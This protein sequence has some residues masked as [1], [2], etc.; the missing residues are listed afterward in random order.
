MERGSSKSGLLQEC[1]TLPAGSNSMIE[2]AMRPASGSLPGC[3]AVESDHMV[4]AST[5]TAAQSAEHPTVRKGFGQ[6]A[7]AS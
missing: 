3:P 4:C 7:S 5:Q 2:G 6:D 1:T